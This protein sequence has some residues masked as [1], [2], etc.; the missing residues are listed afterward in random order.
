MKKR[1]FSQ[2]IVWILLGYMMLAVIYPMSR[3][4]MQ[5]GE[6]DAVKI[7]TSRSFSKALRQSLHVTLTATAISVSLAG[8]LAW[9]LIRTRVPMKKAFELV[10][11]LPMLIPSISHG[12]GLV[13]LLGKN[14]VLTNL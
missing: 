8:I 2:V 3:M 4:F 11:T 10:F 14:G 12:M 5:M 7:L 13:I 1:S 6:T 9:M